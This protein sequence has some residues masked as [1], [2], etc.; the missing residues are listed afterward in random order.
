MTSEPLYLITAATGTTGG[1]ATEILL[2]AGHRVRA[3][4]HRSDDRS[5]R[6]SELGAEIIEGDLTTSSRSARPWP[7][8]PRPTSATPS[9]P[10]DSSRRPP[11]FAQA[12]SEAGVHAVVNMSQISARREAKSHA[13]RSTGSVNDY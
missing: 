7:G 10:D 11:Y 4:V 1:P 9:P 8:S 13:A 3:L 12:A 2:R 5:A 6:L